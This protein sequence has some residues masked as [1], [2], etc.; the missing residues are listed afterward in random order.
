VGGAGPHLRVEGASARWRPDGPIVVSTVDLDLPPGHLVALVGPSGSGKS[1]VAALLVRLLDPVAG[2]VT[3]DGV[4]LRRR[5][6]DDV[7]TLVT[8]VDS[9]AHLFDTSIGTNLRLGRRD[10]GAAELEAVLRRVRLWDWV[11]ALPDGLDTR[12]GE[13]GALVSGGERRRLALA[14][15]LLK[16]SPILVLDEPTEHLDPPTAAAVTADLLDA[17]R[18][19]SVVLITHRPY[20]LD[21]VDT[22]IRLTG[23][24]SATGP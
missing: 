12:V 23:G 21:A 7:R 20:G 24:S 13:G 15:A 6:G 22:I 14:R 9:E 19:R 3:L 17:T 18:G 5:T 16:D 11:R 10:A 8:L 1:T 2:R 4:D